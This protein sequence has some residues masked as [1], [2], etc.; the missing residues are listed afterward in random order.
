MN[1]RIWVESEEG[2]GSV[3]HCTATFGLSKE[4]VRRSTPTVLAKARGLPVLVVDDNATNRRILEDLLFHWGLKPVSADNG[5]EAL[6]RLTEAQAAGQPFAMVLLD[7][8]MPEMDG[9]MLAAEIRENPELVGA[10]LMMLSSADRQDHA[11]RCREAGVSAYMTKPVKRSELLNAVLT[12]INTPADESK[13]T[14]GAAPDRWEQR[15]ALC[16]CC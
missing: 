16:I 15:R 1:G 6:A 11:A 3:F 8:M 9:F 4:P 14:T 5:R 2:R 10:T 13:R 7:D 12:A